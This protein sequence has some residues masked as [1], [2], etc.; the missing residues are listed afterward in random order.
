MIVAASKRV[1]ARAG[2]LG[3]RTGSYYATANPGGPAGSS[4]MTFFM[5]LQPTK[6]TLSLIN[7]SFSRHNGG[8]GGWA[9]YVYNGAIEGFAYNTTPAAVSS[10]LVALPRD[11]PT[12]FIVRYDG[13]GASGGAGVIQAWANGVAT[14]PV[15]SVTGGYL[16]VATATFA[17]ARSDA[18]FPARDVGIL[19]VG[20]LDGYDIAGSI[21]AVNAQWTEDLQ[22]GRYLTWPRAM[23]ASDWYWSARDAASGV[24]GT[25]A[26]WVDRGPNAVVMTRTGSPQSGSVPMVFGS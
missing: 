21:A 2:V 9:M 10:G 12:I 6:Q 19:E 8:P 15:I 26:T 1:A 22:Q 4:L 14:I 7:Y 16:G 18:S 20:M 13:T 5:V 3:F 23:T 24:G 25:K 11:R 17:G